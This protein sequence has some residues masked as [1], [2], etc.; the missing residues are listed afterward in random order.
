[1]KNKIRTLTKILCVD[2]QQVYLDEIMACLKELQ[3]NP[4]G[5]VQFTNPLE[6]LDSFRKEINS[7]SPY[8]LVISDMMMP[9]LSGADLLKEIKKIE[10]A[11]D[12]P[13]IMLTSKSDRETVLKCLNSGANNYIVKPVDKVT[14]AKKIV[15]SWHHLKK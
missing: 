12:I 6:A 10:S 13:C 9:E 5:V 4:S 2:D 1:M 7:G 14:L 11:K 3:F 8:E 15:G